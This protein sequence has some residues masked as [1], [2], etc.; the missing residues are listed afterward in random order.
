MDYAIL[1][2]VVQSNRQA[3]HYELHLLLAKLPYLDMIVSQ[4][5]SR[6]EITREVDILSVLESILHV[7]QE[8][9]MKLLQQLLFQHDIVE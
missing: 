2:Y 9:M 3:S 1:M 6:H 7:D 8:R 4:V 5:T